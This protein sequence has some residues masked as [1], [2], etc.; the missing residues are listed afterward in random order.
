MKETPIPQ[1]GQFLET[2]IRVLEDLFG[3]EWFSSSH[4][5][6]HPAFQKWTLCNE[7]LRRGGLLRLPEDEHRLRAITDL[8]LDNYSLVQATGG[9]LIKF[10][11]GSL[12][13][14][15]D[16]NIRKRI[17]SVIDEASQFLDVLVELN[18]AAWHIS[19]G[20][21][22]QAFETEGYPDFE[23]HIEHLP[24]PLA[25]DCKRVRASTTN[26]RSS[27]LV[28]K[29]NRQIKHL[30]KPSYGLVVIDVS[31][32]IASP[33]S[34]TNGLPLEVAQVCDILEQSLRRHNTS[35][36][37]VLVTWKDNLIKPMTDDSGGHL[38]FIRQHSH[39]VQHEAP[40]HRLPE[41][42]DPLMLA[43]TVMLKVLP[44]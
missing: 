35:V 1:L 43:H 26:R 23:I 21:R 13:N 37:G 7:L 12:A 42:V 29:A 19:R 27:K 31:E 4:K 8:L 30:G 34:R 44:S 22:V 25:T 38:C 5:Q 33:E 3:N 6:H 20:H 18:Y 40:I 2:Q 11:L 36:S 28:N 16:E 10:R 9:E 39:L 14:Y 32:K 15:G 41:N 17:T 24:L